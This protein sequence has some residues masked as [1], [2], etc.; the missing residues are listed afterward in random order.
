MNDHVPIIDLGSNG[1][2]GLIDRACREVGFFVVT[3][4]GVPMPVVAAAWDAARRFFDLPPATKMKANTEGN[5]YG[6][7]PLASEALGRT[8]DGASPATDPDPKQILDLGPPNRGPESGFGSYERIWPT[9]PYELRISWLAYY[10]EMERLADHLLEL[11]AR[12]MNLTPD[13]F[14]PFTDRHLAALR[15]LDYPPADP[16]DSVRAGAHTDYGT[17]TIL[18]PDPTVGG[19]EVADGSGGWIP[20]RAEPDTFVVNIGDLMHRW[21]NGRWRSTLH[22][23]VSDPEGRRRNSMA[24]FHNPNWDATVEPILIE[25]E[26]E[27][28]FDP[29]VAGP[30]LQAKFER[31]TA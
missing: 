22:R 17:L 16:L 29:V 13:H 8:S 20:A 21:T 6:Y 19:L 27:P 10:A 23:V 25:P 11:I 28:R 1:A 5:P 9:E 24:F 12:S 3:G 15:A 4:H 26:E 2:P 18:R 14:V 31:S 30:W 7:Q